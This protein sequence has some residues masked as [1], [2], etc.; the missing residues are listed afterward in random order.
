MEENP[1]ENWR[2]VL[3][4][5]L[6]LLPV[7]YLTFSCAN[8]T[9]PHSSKSR[10]HSVKAKSRS[11]SRAPGGPR[12]RKPPRYDFEGA[13]KEK[14]VA[15]ARFKP[16]A[17][18]TAR[19]ERRAPAVDLHMVVRS[20]M[21]ENGFDTEPSF[22]ADAKANTLNEI[23]VEKMGATMQDMRELLW[24][25]IDNYDPMNVDQIEYCERGQG[26]EILVK[27]AI[28][29]VDAFVPKD[30]I[31]DIH[32][33]GHTLTV[34]TGIETY[35][36]LPENVSGYLASFPYE[37]DRLAL[38]VEFAVLPRG[39]IRPGKIYR[40]VVR[41]RADLAYAEVGAWLDD[42]GPWPEILEEVPGLEEQ[43][44]LQDEASIRLSK[45]RA[46]QGARELEGKVGKANAKM[47]E[48]RAMKNGKVPGLYVHE[49]DRAKRIIENFMI[50][51]N[52]V[53]SGFL[54]GANVPTIHKVVIV[55]KYWNEI[56]DVAKAKGFELPYE[57][58]ANMLSEFLEKVKRTDPE[59]F[60]ALSLRIVRLMGSGEYVMFDRRNPAEYFCRAVTSYTYGTEPNK[61]Y[62]D[63]VLQ[64]LVK[65]AVAHIATP[66]S[67]DE[68]AEIAEL[69]T[70]RE[71]AARQVEKFVTKAKA[72]V[73]LEGK[74]GKTF[75]AV[76]TDVSKR[77]AYAKLVDPPVQGMV[78][79]NG[80]NLQAGQK[81]KVRLIGLEPEKGYVDLEI[82]G[83]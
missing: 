77:G 45:Y 69:C 75:D 35:P 47:R 64:R 48:S 17:K 33:R 7:A 59:G 3:G 15:R 63:L 81:V 26:G 54:E 40:A 79:R 13:S 27:V 38:V 67:K 68:L 31:L 66:Y 52:E 5:L 65:A 56:A 34:H 50:C 2:R 9:M 18:P 14:Y 71:M 44:R 80:E 51:A 4:R 24:S 37:R 82:I 11:S 76:I 53:M 72:A 78:T 12:S 8:S 23:T 55:P 39:N 36:M 70:D 16:H 73:Q 22:I 57:P 49:K 29:D 43:L 10:S 62:V 42:K 28:A 25:S 60:P 74:I 32:A 19:N 1:M 46:E 58:D 30:S 41:N 61:R 6:G 83:E 20:A 21:E